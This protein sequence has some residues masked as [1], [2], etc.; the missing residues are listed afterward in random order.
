MSDE[1]Q[2]L[3]VPTGVSI[4]AGLV[5]SVV[6]DDLIQLQ[7]EVALERNED[8]NIGIIYDSVAITYQITTESFR[9]SPTP[10]RSQPKGTVHDVSAVAT[11]SR[12][13]SPVGSKSISL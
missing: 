4:E 6:V 2:I 9:F 7:G 13:G 10:G 11:H 1:I 8:I 5:I 3:D 12:F